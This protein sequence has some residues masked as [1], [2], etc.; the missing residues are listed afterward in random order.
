[1]AKFYP[2]QVPWNKGKGLNKS[3]GNC[4]VVF[5][6]QNYNKDRRKFCSK[7]CFYMGRELKNTF[8]K[9]HADFVPASS[10]GHTEETKIKI[11]LSQTGKKRKNPHEY[12][13][14][15]STRQRQSFRSLMQK[16]VLERDNYT[17]Q[18]C[19][20]RGGN[21]QVDHI[22]RWADYP[23]LRFNINNCRTLCMPCH[24]YITFKRKMPEGIVWGHNLNKRVSL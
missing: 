23:E 10:R 15:E 4:N 22:K 21:L 14:P 9:G 12:I 1:M 18:I 24:Y 17:C 8:Q 19:N 2:G 13:T 6:V 7:K 16:K 5:Y 3:C 20:C 11:S